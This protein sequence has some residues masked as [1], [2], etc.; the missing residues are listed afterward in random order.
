MNLNIRP[1]LTALLRNRTGA[2]LVAMQIAIALAVLVNALYITTQRIERMRR[3]TGIDV[4]NIFV[5]YSGGF[6]QHFNLAATQQQDLDYLRGLSGVVTATAINAI[7]L[8]GGGSA[9]ELTADPKKPGTEVYNLFDID[10]HGLEALG[11]HLVA[12]RNFRHEEIQPPLDKREGSRFVDQVILSRAAAMK[13]FGEEKPLGRQVYDEIGQVA[14]VIGIVDPVIGSWPGNEHP[15]YVFFT[16]RMSSRNGTGNYYAVRARPGQRDAM[17]RLAEEHLSRSNTDRVITTTRTLAGIRDLTYLGDRTM[18]IY[19]LT[20]TCFLIAVTCLGIFALATFNVSTRTKQIGTRRAVGA[21]R[22]DI[23]QYFLIENGLTTS[24]GI[25]AGC[26]LA[27]AA[28]YWLSLEYALPRLNLYYL[29]GG[30]LVLWGIGQ[31]AAWQPARRAA[32]V[33]P[34]V[35]TRTV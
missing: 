3:P 24:A 5:M 11:V 4:D 25:L 22:A 32:A 10:E 12:G 23:I 34:S 26:A 14:T 29:V 20:V 35:A 1:V 15:D 8:S 18:S 30:V 2:I 19:L 33:S 28:G 13:L 21:R 9:T 17:M 16:P 27:L 7:P 6:T 31:L